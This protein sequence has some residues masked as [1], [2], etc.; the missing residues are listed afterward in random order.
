MRSVFNQTFIGIMMSQEEP[1]HDDSKA[2]AWMAIATIAIVVSTVV[3][4]LSNQG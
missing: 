3:F 1:K 4:W 2:D